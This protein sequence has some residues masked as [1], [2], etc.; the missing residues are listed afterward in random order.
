MSTNLATI[1]SSDME[2]KH[3]LNITSLLMKTTLVHDQQ[4]SLNKA[5]CIL[6][7]NTTKCNGSQSAILKY[8]KYSCARQ[9]TVSPLNTNRCTVLPFITSCPFRCYPLIIFLCFGV[10][11]KQRRKLKQKRNTDVDVVINVE[12]KSLI[13]YETFLPFVRL[14]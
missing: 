7:T 10:F 11:Y 13:R 12:K 3:P 1:Q 5:K 4:Q 14:L 2:Y 9:C 8:G 6:P